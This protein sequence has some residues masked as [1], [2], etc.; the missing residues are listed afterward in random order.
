MATVHTIKQ[1][2]QNALSSGAVSLDLSGLGLTTTLPEAI[3]S[4]TN[5]QSLDLSDNQLTSLPDGLQ[6]LDHFKDIASSRK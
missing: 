1:R 5:L 4:L 3:A 6:K 2:I